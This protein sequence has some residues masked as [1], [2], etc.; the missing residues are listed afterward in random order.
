[1]KFGISFTLT[2]LNQAG[3]LVH[4]YQDGSI[5]LNHG[6]TEMG[7]GLNQ[8][9]A[10]VAAKVFGVDRGCGEDHRDRHGQGAQHLGH[11]G[12][13]RGS[14]LNGMAAKAAAR[15]SAGGWPTSLRANIRPSPAVRSLRKRQRACRGRGADLRGRR[16]GLS[17]AGRCP[18]P[19]SM[20][21]PRSPG[22]A[23]PAGPPFFYFAYG[24]AV[25][26]V[27]IDTL[28]GEN[29]ILRVISCMTRAPA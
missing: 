2:W 18:R 7:Q 29:R 5:H 8:K 1:V 15:R 16:L 23:R 22:T 4:V 11:G 27:V 3:A 6:G 19:A 10:Q 20:P 28:T 25:T 13:K 26:E 12:I 24:A 21:R 9:V 17:G 14:D